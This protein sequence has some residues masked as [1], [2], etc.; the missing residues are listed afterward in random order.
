MPSKPKERGK[1]IKSL[2]MWLVLGSMAWG[3]LLAIRNMF[4]YQDGA[5]NW[6]TLA[7]FLTSSIFFFMLLLV[8]F[9]AIY[10]ISGSKANKSNRE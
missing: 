8:T 10:L 2:L 3:L 4:L 7:V 5:F 9:F 1:F 6:I